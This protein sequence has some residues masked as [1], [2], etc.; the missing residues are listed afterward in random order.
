ML[1]LFLGTP[2]MALFQRYDNVPVD[3]WLASTSMIMVPIIVMRIDR[4]P[5]LLRD[6]IE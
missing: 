3:V 1:L 2:H 6:W 5:R 4:S